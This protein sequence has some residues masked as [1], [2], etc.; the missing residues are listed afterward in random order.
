MCAE[1]GGDVV[2][3]EFALVFLVL[4]KVVVA[5]RQSY[6]HTH[7]HKHSLTHSTHTHSLT[8]SLTHSY[9]LITHN[10]HTH[11]HTYTHIHTNAALRQLRNAPLALLL[12]RALIPAQ[13][14]LA[15]PKYQLGQRTR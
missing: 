5:I 4:V 9:S 8:H 13:R 6:T 3:V 7:T 12:V 15:A 10:K 14:A 2:L 1:G 11:T